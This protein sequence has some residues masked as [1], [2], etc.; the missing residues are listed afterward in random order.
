[1][2]FVHVRRFHEFQRSV[3]ATSAIISIKLY[4]AHYLTLISPI[5][6]IMKARF[7]LIMAPL[8]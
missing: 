4:S 8:G 5:I 7:T 1:M 3:T 6:W 2:A